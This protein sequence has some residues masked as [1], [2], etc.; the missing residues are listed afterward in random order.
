MVWLRLT[1]EMLLPEEWLGTIKGD[2]LLLLQNR[3]CDKVLIRTDS[4]KEL[5]YIPRE[6]NL[7]ADSITKMTFV[8]NE[9]LHLFTENPLDITR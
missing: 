1:Q 2:S 5:D 8:R 9:G 4:T 6:E 7:E 3:H